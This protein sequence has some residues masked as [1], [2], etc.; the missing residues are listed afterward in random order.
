VYALGTEPTLSEATSMIAAIPTSTSFVL[1]LALASGCKSEPPPPQST[2]RSEVQAIPAASSSASV[3][4]GEPQEKPADVAPQEERWSQARLEAIAGEIKGEI[5]ALRG[6]KFKQPVAVNLATREGFLQ[7]AR[8][9]ENETS[10]P[11]KAATDETIAKMLGMIPPGMNLTETEL[12]F[13]AGQ[14]GGFYDPPT[15]S[16]CLMDSCPLGVAKIVLAHEL[17]HALDDQLFDID[18]KMKSLGESSDAEMA[19]RSVVEG[20]GTAVMTQ[21]TIKHMKEVDVSS[22]Q[23]LQDESN[24]SLAAAPMW[25]WKPALAV[26][27]RGAAFLVHSESP[28]A[29][30]LTAAKSEDIRRAFTDVPRSMEQV[31]HPEKYWDA[32]KRDD[33]R[34]VAF[35]LSKL[36]EGWKVL[37]QDTLGEFA[38]T[39]LATPESERKPLDVENPMSIIGLS[40]TSEIG[41]GWGGDRCLLLGK[42]EA[43]VLVIATCWD[44]PRDAAEF[45]G[46]MSLL[47]PQLERSLQALVETTGAY[48]E[49]STSGASLEYGGASD[50]VK[51]RLQAGVTKSEIEKLDKALTY[52]CDA[53]AAH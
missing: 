53:A 20:T 11:E 50:E 2:A 30:Q 27:L 34:S 44:T 16:F 28:I 48:G 33:P 37:R 1:T 42:D 49:H 29:G 45:Y 10:T 47:K 15:K 8:D 14:V 6:E 38:L 31:L 26:Y 17:D 23:K 24:K 21:W 19:Y 46:A 25:L 18:G 22:F 9:H 12:E 35:D 41:K 3:A 52:R 4:R 7:Y 5:E 13:L 32:K 36:P 39:M 40:F 43:R 51:L